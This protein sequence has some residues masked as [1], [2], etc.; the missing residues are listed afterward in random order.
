MT[1][2]LELDEGYLQQMI[3]GLSKRQR[4]LIHG[5]AGGIGSI[6]IQLAKYLGAFVATTVSAGLLDSR[7]DCQK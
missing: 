1:N 7:V 5:G 2:I 6:A 3:P 4:I